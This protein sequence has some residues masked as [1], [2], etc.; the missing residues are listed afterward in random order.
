MRLGR[1]EGTICAVDTELLL[2]LYQVAA[3]DETN[4]DLGTQFLEERQH[5]RAYGLLLQSAIEFI[6]FRDRDWEHTRR[7]GV[8]VPSTSKR[9]T[10]FLMGRSLRGGYWLWTEVDIIAVEG[11]ISFLVV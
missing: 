8:R 7:A 2:L 1:E 5:L 10:V 11:G 6:M 4:C 9:H 3:A